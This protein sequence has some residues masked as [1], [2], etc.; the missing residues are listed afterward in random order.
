MSEREKVIERVRERNN[1]SL[2]WVPLLVFLVKQ[3]LVF[4]K[5]SNIL[6]LTLRVN[7]SN[8]NNSVMYQLSTVSVT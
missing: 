2:F 1:V 8:K 7:V 5:I 6:Y 4:S 3:L